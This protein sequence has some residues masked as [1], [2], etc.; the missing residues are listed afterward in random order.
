MAGVIKRFLSTGFF[1]YG[2]GEVIHAKDYRGAPAIGALD[3]QS[4][5]L[6]VAL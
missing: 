4:P 1:G 2:Q 3:V 6:S 5:S